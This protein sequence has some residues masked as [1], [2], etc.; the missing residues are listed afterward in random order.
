[1]RKFLVGTTCLLLLLLSTIF[2]QPG[3]F[4]LASSVSSQLQLPYSAPQGRLTLTSGSPVMTADASAQS[5]VYYTPYVGNLVPIE[6]AT[7][8]NV[9]P[10]SQLTMALNSTNQT[11]GNLYD[12][13]V[14]LNS[15]TVAIGAGPA[16]ASTTSRGSGAGTSELEQNSGLWVN[17]NTIALAN[18][19]STAT[20]IPATQ[21]TYV[22]TIFLT[23]NGQ[24]LVQFSAAAAPGGSGAVVGL[25]NAYNR[26]PFFSLEKD[27][28]ASWTYS[29][30]SL[31]RAADNSASNSIH[32]VQG[33][34]QT[35]VEATYEVACANTIADDSTYIGVSLNSTSAAPGEQA[36][37]AQN[38]TNNQVS[39][40]QSSRFQPPV[41]YNYVQAMEALWGSGSSSTFYANGVEQSLLLQG[42]Y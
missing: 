27:S 37:F 30:T 12:L 2:L 9:L 21:A 36:Q 35:Q 1:M 28:T 3:R 8:V 18:G 10:F 7:A 5:S 41:G 20:G 32:W 39:I 42:E 24:T 31:W 26:V 25:W 38:V 4:S 23:A 15:G 16:W 40:S 33:L 29:T 6:S 14:F 22:G 19:S 13:F 17:A 11:S 34:A